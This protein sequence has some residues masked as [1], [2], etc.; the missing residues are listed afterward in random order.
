MAITIPMQALIFKMVIYKSMVKI[1]LAILKYTLNLLR[2][3]SH[4]HDLDPAYNN[5]ILHVVFEDDQPVYT[6]SGRLIPTL[7][8]N[9]RIEES[10]V[11]KRYS[12]LKGSMNLIPCKSHLKSIDPDKLRLFFHQAYYRTARKKI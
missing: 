10:S 5:V 7:I 12:K 4:K 1:G 9:G 6:Q 11:L 2:W 3:K 8:L